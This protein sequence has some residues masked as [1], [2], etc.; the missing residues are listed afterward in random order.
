[1]KY[2]SIL[3]C[4]KGL[5]LVMGLL[6]FK[7]DSSGQYTEASSPFM[8][9][10]GLSRSEFSSDSL[11]TKAFFAPSVGAMLHNR[12]G[13]KWGY[14]IAFRFTTR[15]FISGDYKSKL[16]NRYLDMEAGVHREIVSGLNLEVGIA[17]HHLY[18]SFLQFT[19]VNRNYQQVKISDTGFQSNVDFYLGTSIQLEEQIK[20]GLRAYSEA[21]LRNSPSFEMFVSF[22]IPEKIAPNDR[23]VRKMNAHTQ[24]R[25]LRSGTLLVRLHTLDRSIATL[26]ANG[27]PEQAKK[28]EEKVDE[29]NQEL[30]QAFARHFDF[31]KVYFFY[32]V[33]T[34]DIL[35][36]NYENRILDAKGNIV[37]NFQPSGTLF[38]AENGPF[39]QDTT[40]AYYDYAL[41]HSESGAKVEKIPVYRRSPEFGVFC[42]KDAQMNALQDPFPFYVKT[43]GDYIYYRKPNDFIAVL[44]QKLHRYLVKR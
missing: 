35:N 23:E 17:A 31:C 38:F 39:P 37:T 44:N 2:F 9:T 12:I 5:I 25:E 34:S 8:L 24:I 1:M 11:K 18:N 15:G 13:R 43:Y 32:S 16:K 41:I 29:Q 26:R 40:T 28:I 19:D 14:S 10:L 6:M 33:E 4:K 20:L 3:H 22:Q 21:R 30:L 36:G 7:H 42:I 27:M